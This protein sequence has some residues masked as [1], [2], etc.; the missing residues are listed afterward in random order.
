MH[1]YGVP[2]ITHWYCLAPGFKRRRRWHAEA[3]GALGATSEPAAGCGN[4]GLGIRA[5]KQDCRKL[6][7]AVEKSRSHLPPLPP[8]DQKKDGT[9]RIRIAPAVTSTRAADCAASEDRVRFGAIGLKCSNNGTQRFPRDCGD[10]L[11]MLAYAWPALR[12]VEDFR[13]PTHAVAP[14]AL[15]RHLLR[16][17]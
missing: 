3:L 14:S 1:A 6:S 17:V 15:T 12:H 11:R 4:Q 16:P 7:F 2:A 8:R 9:R 5:A 10:M 13:E